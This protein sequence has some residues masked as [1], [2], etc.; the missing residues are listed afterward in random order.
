MANTL[1]YDPTIATQKTHTPRVKSIAFGNGYMQIAGDGINSNLESWSLSWI[2][3][4]TDKQ[5]IEDFFNTTNGYDYF[6][7]TSPENGASQ[8]QYLVTSWNI[9]PLGANFYNIS[10]QFKEW[11]GLV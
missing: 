3:N 7:W 11:A 5:S 8:K 1:T 10:A 9:N 6:N 2:V 4:D